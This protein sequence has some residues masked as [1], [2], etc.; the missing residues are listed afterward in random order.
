MDYEGV[1]LRNGHPGIH[2]AVRLGRTSLVA[3]GASGT[4]SSAPE[5]N[6]S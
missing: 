5:G 3:A 4:F 2:K 6:I 1:R